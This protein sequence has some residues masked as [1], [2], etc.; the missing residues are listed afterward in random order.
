MLSGSGEQ[1]TLQNRKLYPRE[2]CFC[3]C[4]FDVANLKSTMQINLKCPILVI[5]NIKTVYK[6]LLSGHPG[7]TKALILTLGSGYMKCVFACQQLRGNS[8]A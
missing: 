1:A 6:A 2:C 3:S 8:S 5:C 4:T 7:V